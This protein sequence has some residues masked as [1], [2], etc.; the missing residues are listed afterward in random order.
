M[1][2]IQRN[3]ERKIIIACIYGERILGNEHLA[4]KYEEMLKKYNNY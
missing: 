2:K 1:N 4:R 3:E